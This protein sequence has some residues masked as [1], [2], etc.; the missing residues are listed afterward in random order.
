MKQM[1]NRFL[2]LKWL[3]ALKDGE[4]YGNVPG[5]IYGNSKKQ[6]DKNEDYYYDNA[7]TAVFS[8]YWNIGDK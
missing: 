5:L 2:I 6:R 7:N 1:A 8:D 3:I 4:N